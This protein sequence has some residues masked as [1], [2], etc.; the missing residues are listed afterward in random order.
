MRIIDRLK[1]YLD[2][3]NI[4]ARSFERACGLS[5]GYLQKQVKGKGAIG[6]EILEKIHAA[7]EELSLVWL[8]TGRGGMTLQY[9]SQQ[10]QEEAAQYAGGK[11]EL[12]RALRDQ[13]AVLQSANADKDKIIMLLEQQLKWDT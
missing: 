6:S 12:I 8:F 9:S 4:T 2:S 3:R 7:Y 11:D 13:V 10:V 1:E 5:N